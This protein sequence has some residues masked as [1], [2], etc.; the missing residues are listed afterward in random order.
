MSHSGSS[1]DSPL[2]SVKWRG[3]PRPLNT[4]SNWFEGVNGRRLIRKDI[5]IWC[6]PPATTWPEIQSYTIT[7][8][9]SSHTI[10]QMGL[11]VSESRRIKRL[12]SLLM[13]TTQSITASVFAGRL[14]DCV[15]RHTICHT[16]VETTTSQRIRQEEAAAR[17]LA[18]QIIQTQ[19]REWANASVSRYSHIRQVQKRPSL[20][21]KRLLDPFK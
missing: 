21:P 5:F 4:G 20:I 8:T 15:G 6:H 11:K 9:T 2:T 18:R 1:Q 3:H 14:T 12:F 13:W 16:R 19:L 17:R 7:L 10:S